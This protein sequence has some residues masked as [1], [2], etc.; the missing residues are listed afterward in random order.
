MILFMLAPCDM[1][2]LQLRKKRTEA[3]LPAVWEL[4]ARAAP[5][6]RPVS[7]AGA[8]AVP[9]LSPDTGSCPPSFLK[10]QPGTV[11]SPG[12]MKLV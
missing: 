10:K 4:A 5:G 1:F 8:A 3:D 2:T 11:S 9:L 12:S 7:P 6:A